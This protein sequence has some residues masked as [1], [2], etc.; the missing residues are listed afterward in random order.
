MERTLQA[1]I[2]TSVTYSPLQHNLRVGMTTT[3]HLC[4]ILTI[5]RQLNV[6]SKF[7]ISQPTHLLLP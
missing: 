1:N 4:H 2:I 7:R 3:G 5:A 6:T